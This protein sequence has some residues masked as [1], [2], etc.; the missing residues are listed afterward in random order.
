MQNKYEE[1]DKKYRNPI[2]ECKSLRKDSQYPM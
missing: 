1:L 2:K